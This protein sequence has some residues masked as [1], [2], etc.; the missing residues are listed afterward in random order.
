MTRSDATEAVGRL[1]AGAVVAAAAGWVAA[2]VGWGVWAVASVPE[3]VRVPAALLVVVG[4]LLLALR[5][6]GSYRVAGWGV[7]TLAAALTAGLLGTGW[8]VSGQ[9]DIQGIGQLVVMAAAPFVL[10]ALWFT[11]LVLRA[12]LERRGSDPLP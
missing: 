2:V 6:A 9:R 11:G 12:R 3:L 8:V 5:V 4:G 1:L 10:G 7:L